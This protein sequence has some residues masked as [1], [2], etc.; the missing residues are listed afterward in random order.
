MKIATLIATR[1][2]VDSL[3]STSLPCLRAQRRRPDRVVIVS[4]QRSLDAEEAARCLAC[5]EGLQV[6]VLRNT[7]T[8]G[9]AG[10]WNTGLDF[11]AAQD[12]PDF[13]ALLDDDDTWD[14]DHLLRCEAEAQPDVDVVISGLRLLRDGVEAPREPL[15]QVAAEDFLVG[16]PGW[17]GTNTFVRMSR[18]RQVGGFCDGL[19]SANDRDLAIRLLD[20]PDLKVAFTGRMTATWH[21]GRCADALSAWGSPD[22][23]EG[24][25]VFYQRYASRLTPTQRHEAK[26]RAQTLFGV[27]LT[28]D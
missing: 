19:R 2:R 16:N 10:A 21:L 22:K 24:L 25:R 15:R 12:A 28:I 18:L 13:V 3:L 11:L 5:C 23:R 8:P 6:Q 27:D 14:E 20:L 7:R 9:A 1:P 4:D 26:V 17:Q